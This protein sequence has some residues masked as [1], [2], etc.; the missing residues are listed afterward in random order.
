MNKPSPSE[1]D[2]GKDVNMQISD[3]EIVGMIEDSLQD[4]DCKLI[5]FERNHQVFGNMIVKIKSRN[6]KF[7]FITD[8]GEVYCNKTLIF[9][10]DYHVAGED[11]CPI[12]L[13]K[14]IRKIIIA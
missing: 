5:S 3:A 1:K 13:I 8:R 7:I 10:N 14:A 6:K 4:S 2:E 12:Y 11:D 9:F